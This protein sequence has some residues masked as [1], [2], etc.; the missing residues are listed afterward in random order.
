MKALCL[1]LPVVAMASAS[2]AAIIASGLRDIVISSTFGGVYLDVDAGVLV[3]EE[4]AGWD[5]NPFFGG[6]GIANSPAFQAVRLTVNVAS[7]VLNLAF[8]QTV[9]GS[10]TFAAGYAGSDSHIGPGPSQFDSGGEGYIGFKLTTNANS[11]PYYG[12]IRLV[13]ANDGS[14]GLIRDWAYDDSGS[15]ITIG[16]IPEPSVPGLSILGATAFCFR[17]KRRFDVK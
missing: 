7:P 11:G 8:G 16:A 17:R 14:T 1:I 13:L 15:A 5:I 10:S 4:G 12:W 9:S 2:H 6:E 3:A